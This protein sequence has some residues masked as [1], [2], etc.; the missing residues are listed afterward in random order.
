VV[1][2]FGL[3]VVG[4]INVVKSFYNL[5][6]KRVCFLCRKYLKLKLLTPALCVVMMRVAMV[7][8]SV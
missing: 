6:S 4:G 8:P 2:L 3:W 5:I 1:E 7:I